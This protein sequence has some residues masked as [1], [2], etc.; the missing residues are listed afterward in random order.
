MADLATKFVT[1]SSTK[2][3]GPSR[4]VRIVSGAAIALA[5]AAASLP[6]APAAAQGAYASLAAGGQEIP[7][8]YQARAGR[9]LWFAQPGRQAEALLEL[10]ASAELDGLDPGRYRLGPLARAVR[11]ARSGNRGAVLRADI[12]LSQALVAYARDLKR[13]QTLGTVYVDPELRPAPPSPRAI[14]E[15]AAAAP[16]LERHVARLGWMHPIY[17]ELRHALTS[18]PLSPQQRALGRINLE[19]ARELPGGRGRHVVVNSAAQRL[20]IYE[21]GRVVD[22]MRVVVGQ[23]KYPTPMMSALI[24]YA[25]LNPYWFVPPDLAAERIAPNVVRLGVKYLRD[26]GYQVVDDF[27]PSPRI[28]DPSTI[29]WQAVAD[30]RTSVLIRQLPGPHNAMGRMKFMFPNNEGIYLHDTPDKELL[31]EAARMFSGGCVRLEDAERFG[32]WLF[33]R[34]LDPEGARA[35]HEVALDRPVP[36]YLTYLTAV[37]SGPGLTFFDDIYGR[38]ATRLAQLRSGPAFAATR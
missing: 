8:F 15:A 4:P 34:D 18:G 30:G 33:G 1:S 27:V 9:P 26:K 10:L 21:N 23:P 13:P 19:R 14:L 16:S 35:E 3:T 11:A 37:P 38:D 17:G 7:D 5:A 22:S 32:R 29:D 25:A 20:D 31:S 24:R 12:M 36:V 2:R 28:I 6:A